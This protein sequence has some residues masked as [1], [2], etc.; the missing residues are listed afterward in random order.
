MRPLRL[1]QLGPGQPCPSTSSHQV[2]TVDFGGNALGD[3][4]VEPIVF[5]DVSRLNSWPGGWYGTKT[6]WFAAPSYAGAALIRGA[7]IDGSGPMGFGEAPVIGHLVIPPGPTINEGADGYRQAPGG[8]FV[9]SSGCYA[10]QVDGGDFTY[11]IVF[12]AVVKA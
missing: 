9:K 10:W 6:L 4:D 11:V 8:T 7:R 12:K 3:G 2:K 1:P 5:G